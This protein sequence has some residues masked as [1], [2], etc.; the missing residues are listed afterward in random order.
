MDDKD[1]QEAGHLKRVTQ[2]I[3]GAAY[4]E[5]KRVF[6]EPFLKETEVETYTLF[7]TRRCSCLAYIYKRILA[8]SY[9]RPL[10]NN[11]LLT[12][13]AFIDAAV[14]IA[15]KIATS[16]FNGKIIL[17]D[18]SISFGRAVTSILSSFFDALE[19]RLITKNVLKTNPTENQEWKDDFL[20]NHVE[21]HIYMKKNQPDLLSSLQGSIAQ[22]VRVEKQ[23]T[24]NDFSTRV[25]E[26]INSADVANAAYVYSSA[27]SKLPAPNETF[28]WTA[29]D[30]VYSGH[31][32]RTFF[33]AFPSDNPKMI[34]SI[35][36]I[37][38][39]VNTKYRI[40]P[41][42]LLPRLSETL[43]ETIEQTVFTAQA[44]IRTVF[45][46]DLLRIYRE[47]YTLRSRA[48]F[49]TMYLSQSLLLDFADNYEVTLGEFDYEK[50]NWTYT[51]FQKELSAW[52]G[53]FNNETLRDKANWLKA[54]EVERLFDNIE[55]EREFSGL[56]EIASLV[57]EKDDK[58][59]ILDG[60]DDV[61]FS[62]AV[63][64]E[65]SSQDLIHSNK[66]LSNQ[67]RISANSNRSNQTLAEFLKEYRTN[68]NVVAGVDVCKIGLFDL[69]AATLQM[70]DAGLMSIVAGYE[71]YEGNPFL[72]Q[73]IRVC[74]QAL[75]VKPR[76]YYVFF[77]VLSDLNSGYEWAGPRAYNYVL[78]TRIKES[79]QEYL[80]IL[81]S[82]KREKNQ[83]K[84]ALESVFKANIDDI[85]S[86]TQEL[87]DFLQQLRYCYQTVENWMLG[88]IRRFKIDSTADEDARL[89]FLSGND[90][91]KENQKWTYRNVLF[92]C[93]LCKGN[94]QID[95]PF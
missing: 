17:V 6:F 48:E 59:K 80:E 70:M 93:Y 85:K 63:N 86:Q 38:C 66:Y 37:P 79:L 34:C 31:Q 60:F 21:I 32:Q 9:E 57:K 91:D 14:D 77:D 50:V 58:Q 20:K 82:C 75:C 4:Y 30:T 88:T 2:L 54:T 64:F 94:K 55:I 19:K 83:V 1:L 69:L 11:H 78:N 5:D 53:F 8:D 28:G 89:Q 84:E 7:I 42:V 35:R 45:N 71:D 76:R 40:V 41:F 87:V 62:L 47:N 56:G 10:K 95:C 27:I 90:N 81:Q 72:V 15:D 49:I 18:D 68:R 13:S 29:V 73:R 23:S 61:L 36:C 43:I 52:N 3:L 51:F 44:S 46:K 16:N 39:S 12:N 24:W 25:S 22:I 26:L 92:H 74:E 65:R 33:K 67:Q